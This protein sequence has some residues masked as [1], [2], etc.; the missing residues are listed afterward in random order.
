MS[1]IK[2]ILAFQTD[3][4]RMAWFNS[5]SADEQAEVLKEAREISDRLIEAFRPLTEAL[6]RIYKSVIE[7]GNAFAMEQ[8]K[9]E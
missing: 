7:L 1:R 8:A 4:E 3:E 6:A 5:L 9:E 2:E